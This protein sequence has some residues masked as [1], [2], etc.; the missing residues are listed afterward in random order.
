MKTINK[1]IIAIA[2]I[3]LFASNIF[4]AELKTS[5]MVS[6]VYINGS[7]K[8]G[9]EVVSG[10]YSKICIQSFNDIIFNNLFNITSTITFINHSEVYGRSY[11]SV[12]LEESYYEISEFMLNFNLT[13]KSV[14]SLGIFNFK[15]SKFSEYKSIDLVN[16][17][18]LLTLY[19]LQFPGIIYTNH[20]ENNRFHLGYARRFKNFPIEDR[21]EHSTEGSDLLYAFDTIN[22]KNFETTFNASTSLIKYNSLA[23]ETIQDL[24]RLSLFGVG[25]R[26]DNSDTTGESYYGIGAVSITDFDGTSISPTGKELSGPSYNFS[27]EDSRDG[28]SLLLGYN[29]IFDDVL[30]DRSLSIT[31]EYFY[32][33]KYWVS[34]VADTDNLYNYSWGRLGHTIQLSNRIE[35][36]DDL[37]VNLMYGYSKIDYKKLSGGNS[38]I[39]V[40]DYD[41]G[42]MLTLYYLF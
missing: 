17:D 30:F 31:A 9:D 29:K 28:Y 11:N 8:I 6:L 3:S 23:D 42:F 24:G 14:L 12:I 38:V 34:Y 16:S 35:L 21:Y 4:S 25:L 7:S 32:A 39:E 13:K 40:D 5:N 18:A 33:S 10:D 20:L 19:Y 15:N 36:Y 2:V 27:D 26:L 22:Y 37:T 1:I 41:K